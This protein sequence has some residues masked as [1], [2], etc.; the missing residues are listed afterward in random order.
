VSRVQ[1]IATGRRVA[2][3]IQIAIPAHKRRMKKK[4]NISLVSQDGF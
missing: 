4:N 3:A 2:Q 1:T